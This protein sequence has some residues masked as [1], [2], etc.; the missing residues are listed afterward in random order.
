MYHVCFED[1]SATVHSCMVQFDDQTQVNLS[2]DEWDRIVKAG[3]KSC[4]YLD[5]R[6]VELI[7]MGEYS[8]SSNLQAG[9]GA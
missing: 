8:S 7:K 2:S 3:L 5:N 9:K 4:G 1:E 6:D